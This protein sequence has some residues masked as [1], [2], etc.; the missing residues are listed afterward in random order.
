MS[1]TNPNLM[2]PNHLHFSYFQGQHGFVWRDIHT[3]CL[4]T[5]K[6]NT[7]FEKI[8][9]HYDRKG[10]GPWWLVA[11]NIPGITWRQVPPLKMKVNHY[12][13][14]DQRLPCDLYRLNTLF[15]EG[16]VYADLDF[17][18]LGDF[19]HLLDKTAFIGTQ[20]LAK[21]KLA[22][23]LMG[24]TMASA[25]I[26]EYRKAYKK[27]EPQ[28]EKK[29]WEFANSVPWDLAHQHP[30]HILPMDTFYPWRWSNKT[31]LQGVEPRGFKNAIACHL[32]ES[33]QPNLTVEDLKKTAL[34]PTIY[35]VWST[36]QSPPDPALPVAEECSSESPS[37]E[38]SAESPPPHL[39]A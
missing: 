11:R 27:W 12:P 5:A 30:C 4:L 14:V 34:G 21:K 25:F 19:S 1:G 33:I 15:N 39:P 24:S 13:V 16:G 31:F 10:E 29:F 2:I 23:G 9:V 3:L 20:C 17:V 32:W 26:R 37:A 28:H 22:C 6:A 38:S 35:K 36:A 8:T 18:F 7:T